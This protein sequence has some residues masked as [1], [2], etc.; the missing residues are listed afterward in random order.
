[1]KKDEIEILERQGCV[2][3]DWSLVTLD[4]GVDLSRIRNVYFSGPVSVGKGTEI[5]NVP[6]GLSNVR[7]GEGARIVNAAR[8][9][10]SP[11][12]TYGVGI[13]IAVLDET[14]TRP[15]RIYPGL[16]A[17]IATMA[18]RLPEYA[19]GKLLPLITRHIIDLPD[20]KEIGAGAEVLDCGPITEVRIWPGSKVEGVLRLHNGSIVNNARRQETRT[21]TYVGHG[22]D[23]ENFII[24]DATVTGGS[25]LS[26]TY[27]GQ[28]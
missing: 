27:V 26:N 13:D 14:G 20:M 7:I 12:A 9:E 22:V 18:A 5:I 4:E 1:M 16:S 11:G 15:V 10:N 17:Q 28:G 19:E 21:L 24:E 8:I 2:S 3:D 23:A 25:I 6:G